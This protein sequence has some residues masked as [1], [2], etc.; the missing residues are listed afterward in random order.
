MKNY[1]KIKLFTFVFCLVI[2]IFVLFV[3]LT[4][5]SL[6]KSQCSYLDP[7]TIDFLAFGVAI[8]LVVEGLYR[9]NEHKNMGLKKQSTR[10]VR[11]G[12]GCAIIT[13]HILQFLHK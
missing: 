1:A 7:V 10:I 11:V 2:V 6:L 8:F 9:I 3:Q 13:L 4:G 5:Q 12:I